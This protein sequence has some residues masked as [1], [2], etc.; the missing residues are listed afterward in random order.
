MVEKWGLDY[1]DRIAK[2]DTKEPFFIGLAPVGPHSTTNHSGNYIFDVPEVENKY[3]NTYDNYKIPRTASFN[4]DQPHG[5]SWVKQLPK[6]TDEQVDYFDLFYQRRLGA[7]RS[8]DD[9]VEAVVKKLEETGLDKN[10]YII[11][12][13]YVRY[14]LTVVVLVPNSLSRR[15]FRSATM[16]TPSYVASS[17]TM[18][19]KHSSLWS[20][21]SGLCL[22]QGSHRR[23]PGKSTLYESDIRIPLVIRGPGIKAGSESKKPLHSCSVSALT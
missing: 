18:P 11:Y 15:Q 14:Y 22:I 8:V 19:D 1:L 16:A 2:S 12:S 20:Q 4:P 9:L 6:L 10:T 17:T 5:A 21:Y 23:Q 13:G 7:V 3:W